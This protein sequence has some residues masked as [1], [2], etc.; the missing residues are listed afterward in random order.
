MFKL[1]VDAWQ[2]LLVFAQMPEGPDGP[3]R[4]D[5]PTPRRGGRA[6]QSRRHPLDPSPRGGAEGGSPPE[7]AD[8]LEEWRRRFPQLA[9]I[10]VLV[11]ALVVVLWPGS[12]LVLGLG[13]LL[14]A[15]TLLLILLVGLLVLLF[16][17]RRTP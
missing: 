12:S 15:L 1:R 16:R 7:G 14:A 6:N 8:R 13:T 4:P 17:G 2:T 11:A 3:G 9:G 10:G 5:R